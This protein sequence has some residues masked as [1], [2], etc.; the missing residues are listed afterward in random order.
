MR[1]A[2]CSQKADYKLCSVFKI[3]IYIYFC[4]KWLVNI[5]KCTPF[6]LKGNSIENSQIIDQGYHDQLIY[7]N[8]NH[9]FFSNACYIFNKDNFVLSQLLLNYN[10]LIH[11]A[12]LFKLCR[13][14]LEKDTYSEFQNK[15]HSEKIG[16]SASATF[17]LDLLVKIKN[18]S[19]VLY[20]V[21][22]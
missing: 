13:Q 3:W 6:L 11:K 19:D 15:K 21:V 9:T 1:K 14:Y 4:S 22:P 7:L 10:D 20:C 2:V 17:D 5:T 8:Y 12:Y 16:T 18:T